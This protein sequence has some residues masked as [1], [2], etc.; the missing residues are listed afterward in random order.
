MFAEDERILFVFAYGF[1]INR[2]NQTW[3]QYFVTAKC[4]PFYWNSTKLHFWFA[5]V[6][7]KC[8]WAIFSHTLFYVVFYDAFIYKKVAM[9]DLHLTAIKHYRS[10]RLPLSRLMNELEKNSF[11]KT[12]A[13]KWDFINFVYKLWWVKQKKTQFFYF[14]NVTKKNE[15]TD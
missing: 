5:K 8:F 13:L 1:G 9:H 12:V 15:L 11:A 7:I 3:F 14:H 6:K 10:N 2:F 4:R